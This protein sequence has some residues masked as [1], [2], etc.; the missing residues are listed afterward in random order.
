MDKKKVTP[1]VK[2]GIYSAKKNIL[3]EYFFIEK[4]EKIFAFCLL[5]IIINYRAY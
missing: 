4:N 1:R 5:G 2:K 3:Q